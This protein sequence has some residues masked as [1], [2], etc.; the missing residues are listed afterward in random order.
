MKTTIDKSNICIITNSGMG[1]FLNPPT[2]PEHTLSVK[3]VYG[4]KFSMSLSSA[5]ESEW[6]NDECRNKA[7][8]ILSSQQAPDINSQEVKEWIH[9][10]LGYFN[11]CYSKDGKNRNVST[12]LEIIKDDPFEAKII[13]RHLGVMLIREYYPNYVPTVEDFNKA[14]W[15]KQ[16]CVK[17]QTA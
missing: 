7:K 3:S 10:V 2:H 13:D 9:E 11:H 5:I 12:H 6:L 4:D 8:E 1:G 17:K 15:G 16:L 14:H